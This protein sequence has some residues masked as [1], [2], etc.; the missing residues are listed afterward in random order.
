MFLFPYSHIH[1]LIELEYNVDWEHCKLYSKLKHFEKVVIFGYKKI[2]DWTLKKGKPVHAF[3]FTHIYCIKWS[4]ELGTASH[5]CFMKLSGPIGLHYTIPLHFQVF[6][7]KLNFFMW[8]D[9]FYLLDKCPG[10]GLDSP[11]SCWCGT[12]TLPIYWCVWGCW[13][14]RHN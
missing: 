12:K 8:P 3:F 6:P 9:K 13:K 5:L 7:Q 14:Y 11:L 1:I 4:T 10:I 2:K